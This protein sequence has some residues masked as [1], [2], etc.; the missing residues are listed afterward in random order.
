[1]TPL[2]EVVVSI[3]RLLQLMIDAWEI[4]GAV[5]RSYRLSSMS[6]FAV[7]NRSP[8]RYS[9]VALFRWRQSMTRDALCD[10][11]ELKGGL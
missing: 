1:M 8:Q 5:H 10:G 3:E 7:D 9:P 6:I 4:E 11:G 2:I